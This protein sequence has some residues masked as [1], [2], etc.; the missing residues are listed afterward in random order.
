M[1]KRTK[2][3]VSMILV[4][5]LL[6]GTVGCG[7]QK[8]VDIVQ[9]TEM[10][11]SWVLEA[12]PEPVVGSI[13]GDWAVK[14]VL[15]SGLEDDRIDSFKQSYIDDVNAQAKLTKGDIDENYFTTYGRIAIGLAAAGE[16]SLDV[17][18]YNLPKKLDNMEKIL[19]QGVIG[20]SYALIGA[21][22]SGY[23]LKNE[24]K[25][26]DY[27]VDEINQQELYDLEVWV[28]MLAMAVEALS[29]YSE[30]EEIRETIEKSLDGLARFQ[31][32]DGSYGNCESTAEVIIAATM[33]GVD[34]KTDERFVKDGNTLIDGLLMFKAN[35]QYL[36]TVDGKGGNTQMS[37]EKALL[38]LV[39][40]KNFEHG[41]KLYN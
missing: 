28:D 26:V 12:T 33:A 15:D 27:L 25:Y 18:G 9:E 2:K 16:D 7:G 36:H 5:V 19:E 11:A 34:L 17:Q 32:E 37:T 20:C 8:E 39:A 1:V 24:E 4:L 35:D 10:T 40:L 41:S 38:A 31:K 13:G 14:G 21:K 22:V 6:I 30:D 29:Y 3:W 23:D